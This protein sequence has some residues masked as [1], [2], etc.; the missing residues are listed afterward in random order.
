MQFLTDVSVQH[1]GSIFKGKEF[2]DS[3]PLKMGPISWT[4]TSARNCIY[5]LRYTP[6][7]RSSRGLWSSRNPPGP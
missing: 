7:E 3:W 4:E 2:L 6:E 5:W 1:V